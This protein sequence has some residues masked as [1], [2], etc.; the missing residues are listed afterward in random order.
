MARRK[1]SSAELTA[2][3]SRSRIR[4][5]LLGE[6]RSV[7]ETAR[8]QAA[9]EVNS[10][11]VLMNWQIG[12]R[13]RT[14]VLR[15]KR[16]DYGKEMIATLSAQ[17][18]AE[19]GRGFSEKGLWR[20]L[21]LAECFPD[22][23]IVA[24]L[25]RQLGWSHFVELIPLE[26]QLKRDF[27]AELCRAERWSVRTLR[28]KIQTLLFERTAVSKKPDALIRQNIA[29]LRDED[30]L[31]PD[32]VF[33]DP[34]FLE[35]LGLSGQHSEKDV[36]RAIVQEMESFILELGSDFA[37][38]A[39]QKRMTV[40]SEDYDLDLLFYHRR[41]SCL[42]AIDL[43]LGRFQAADKG[44]MELYLRW[45]EKHEMRPREAPPIG[46]ILCADKSAEHVELLRLNDSGIRVAQYLTELPT[47]KLLAKKLSQALQQARERLGDQRV[48]QEDLR[49]PGGRQS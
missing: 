29:A 4:Q 6:I 7:I 5:D 20:M 26:D 3:G 44:Q 10:S 15:H 27:Y 11:L 34:Y 13:I 49:R 21:Q 32:M 42:V 40:D 41:L 2:P 17:L 30:R 36:E 12:T 46:L 1:T 16:A 8:E 19:Y 38:V 18:V 47:K 14:E 9:R 35:F 23:E 33:R 28:H 45:L 37:F 25:S 24:T 48:D 43:K 39:R 22:R 31:T